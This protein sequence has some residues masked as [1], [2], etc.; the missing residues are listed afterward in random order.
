M[1]RSARRKRFIGPLFLLLAAALLCGGAAASPPPGNPPL[2]V[3]MDN[4]YPPYVFLDSRGELQ[5]ILID[6]WHLWQK[7]TGRPVA[8]SGLD[9]NTAL[10]RME[11]GEFDVIDTIFYNEKRA[12]IYEFSKPYAKLEV[13]I[14]FHQDISGIAG[15]DSLKGFVVAVKAGDAAVDFLKGKGIDNLEEFNSYEA[16]FLAARDRK[17]V[18]FMVDTPPAMYFLYKMGLHK[19]FRHTAPLYVGKFHRAVRKGNTEL[20]GLIESGFDAIPKDDYRRIERHWFG[21][22]ADYGLYLRY[23]GFVAAAA[24]VLIILLAVWNILL[25]RT[26]HQKTARLREEFF[27]SNRRAEA[28]RESEEEFRKA[29][30][31]SPDAININRLEDGLYV[32]INEGFAKI[33]GYSEEEIIGKTSLEFSIWD[34]QEDRKRLIEGLRRDGEVKNLEAAFRMKEGNVRYGL[35]SAS[36]ID[37]NGVP[38]ILSLTRDITERKRE[39][40]ERLRLQERLNRAEKIEALGTLAGGVAHDLN[41]VLGVLI[42]YSELLLLHLPAESPLKPYATKIM[43]GGQ[44]AAAIIQDLLTLARRGVV[45]SEVINLNH[46]VSECLDTPEFAVLRSR[47]P[48]IAF[49]SA[50][51]PRLLNIKGSPVHLVKTL[52]NLVSNAAEAISG[53]GEVTIRTENRYIDRPLPTYEETREGEYAVLIVLDTGNGIPA[54]DIKRIFEPF[55]TK[56]VMGRSGT[57]LGLA[58]VWGTVKDHHGYID[59]RS[60]NGQ[61]STFTLYFPASRE[62]L[63]EERKSV[64]REAYQGKGERILVVDDVEGQRTLAMVMLVGLG[65]EVHAVACGEEAVAYVIENPVDLLVLDMIMD[66]YIDGLE[67]YKRI[68]NIHP[69]Q[70]A[71]IVSGFAEDERVKTAQQLGAGAYIRKP[72]LQEIMGLAVRRELDRVRRQKVP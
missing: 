11:A 22:P 62:A 42:G 51:D 54:A 47:H 15:V 23:A 34:N 46:T 33:T 59:V 69:G 65:Y 2:R 40:E 63:Q 68:L 61:G 50:P 18:T 1:F 35:M 19:Q 10:R 26:V 52:M 56:K 48:D 41:N 44:R 25:R 16:I 53:P 32:S 64:S 6:Q 36:M 27:L 20:L 5:G 70:K 55:Y 9:W 7:K 38:H 72:Y 8:I 43:D 58:V 17:V 30:N 13:P 49:R 3:V 21:I 37:L 24:V 45:V 28:L 66:P 67:T 57:G 71:V 31:T 60:E 39:E 14:F 29:F 4:N 12:K